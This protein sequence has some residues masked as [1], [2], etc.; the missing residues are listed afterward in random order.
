GPELEEVGTLR[1]LEDLRN[2]RDEW[3]L[4]SGKE[5]MFP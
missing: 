2:L 1:I 5:P 4:S 3:I